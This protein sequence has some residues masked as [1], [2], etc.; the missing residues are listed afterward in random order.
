MFNSLSDKRMARRDSLKRIL[1]TLLKSPFERNE[2]ENMDIISRDNERCVLLFQDAIYYATTDAIREQL[3]QKNYTIY[4]LE[5]ELEARGFE[6]FSKSGVRIIDYEGAID[7][8]ME[9]NDKVV[10]L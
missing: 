5:D 7:L 2:I 4:A 10:S 8:V 9:N 6:S 1:F 3:L